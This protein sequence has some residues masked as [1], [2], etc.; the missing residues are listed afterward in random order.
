MMRLICAQPPPCTGSSHQLFFP[1]DS[2]QPGNM[3]VHSEGPKAVGSRSCW[4]LWAG[5]HLETPPWPQYSCQT[6]KSVLDTAQM[7]TPSSK[8]TLDTAQVPTPSSKQTL[9]RPLLPLGHCPDADPIIEADTTSSPPDPNKKMPSPASL[10][11]LS[12]VWRSGVF[13]RHTESSGEDVKQRNC[14]GKPSG[15]SSNS[16]T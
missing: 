8:Q 15:S 6:S 5:C 7:L 11:V 14:H 10:P 16:L 4:G 3:T 13:S 2:C 1:R 12:T 9:T